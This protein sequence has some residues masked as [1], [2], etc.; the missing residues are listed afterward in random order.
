MS[1]DEL[2]LEQ[3]FMEAVTRTDGARD[4]FLDHACEGNTVLRQ[5]VTALLAAHDAAGTFLSLPQARQET[6]DFPP[7]SEGPG[8]RIGRYKLLEQIGEGGFGV[9]FM[10]EQE[11][12]VRRRVAFKIIKLGMDTRQVVARFEAERQ[13]LAMMDHT[14]IAKVFDAGSTDTGRPFFVMELVRGISITEYCNK[15]KL[16]TRERLKL[17]IAMCAGVQHAHQKGIIHRDLK[18]SNILVTLHDDKAVPKIIDFGIAKATQSRLTEKTLFTE[19]RQMVGTPL[20]MSPEQ[21]QMSGLDV[22]TRSD[23]YS[24][25]VLLYEL[26]TGTTPIE[27][28]QV[29]TV[30]YDQLRQMICEVDPPSPSTRLSSLTAEARATLATERQCDPHRLGQLL[31]GDLD[32]IVMRCLE[33]D[34]TR[35]YP[36]ANA[37]AMDVQRYLNDEPVEARRPTRLYRLKKF[38]RRNKAS[39]LT[40]S[41]IAALL[42]ATMVTLWVSNSRI[43]S[44]ADARAIALEAKD[45]ALK[46]KDAALAT[47]REA[48]D[49]MLTQ[50]ASERFSDMPLSYPLRIAL[51]EDAMSFYER[52]ASQSGADPALR[53]EMASLL[54]TNAG[55][56]REMGR[57]DHAIRALRQSRDLLAVLERT[58]PDPPEL[59]EERARVELDL[60]FTLHNG[61]ESRLMDDREAQAQ[62]RRSLELFDDI[63]RNWP[64]RPQ[65]VMLGLRMVAKVAFE[66]GEQTEALGLWHEAL[67]RGEKY[68]DQHPTEINAATEVGWTCVHLCDAIPNDTTAGQAEAES[69]V[70]RGLRVVDSALEANPKS[71]QLADVAAALRIRLATLKCRQG[72]AAAAVPLFQQAVAGMETLCEGFPWNTDYWNSLRWFH[73]EI[74]SQLPAAGNADA[75]RRELT[76]FQDWLEK[77]EP[78]MSQEPDRQEQLRLCQSL[79]AELLQSLENGETD[80]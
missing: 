34:R 63:E 33:K 46:D 32:W 40:G 60:A 62:Y 35:R 26:L 74:A 42:L 71:T 59:K 78:Q 2:Q 55:L 49:Q 16:D 57:E 15:A 24:L 10:A 37:L 12:P 72:Q 47:A 36:T 19:F 50:V 54:H 11:E 41:A 4:D 52:L 17:F 3:I 9:V 43:R 48:V 58:D 27:S 64:G 8:T 56:L 66:Q 67:A 75:A 7:L 1:V 73:Q 21:A 69:V 45:A 31:R 39:V 76:Q 18:P 51:L 23:I 20:Y 13:A 79:V 6:P 65:S 30:P 5:R 28:S 22:D 38:I 25:G 68:L 44:E 77:I 61:D 14:N 80:K 53:H 70:T 29:K